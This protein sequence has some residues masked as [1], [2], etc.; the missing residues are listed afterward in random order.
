VLMKALHEEP[1][2]HRRAADITEADEQHSNHVALPFGW[3]GR[4]G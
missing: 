2:S 3:W 1:L 4:R